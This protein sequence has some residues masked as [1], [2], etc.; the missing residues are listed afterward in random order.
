MAATETSVPVPVTADV[1]VA[2]A[3]AP[4]IYEFVF[5]DAFDDATFAQYSGASDELK[6]EIH[7]VANSLKNILTLKPGIRTI[8]SYAYYGAD[9]FKVTLMNSSWI[10]PPPADDA[11]AA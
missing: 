4:Y 2:S 10:P 3:V 8:S 9:T 5:N 6:A 7:K 1:P 11:V